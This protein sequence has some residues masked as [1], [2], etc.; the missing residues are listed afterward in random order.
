MAL[1]VD[2]RGIER[3]A[4]LEILQ[5]IERNSEALCGLV[6]DFVDFME[7]EIKAVRSLSAAEELP[8]RELAWL[9]IGEVK[10]Q[11]AERRIL[12][13]DKLPS[14][15][16]RLKVHK[17]TLA[18]ALAH[19]LENAVKF[20]PSG[21]I[22]NLE[23]EKS[24]DAVRLHVTDEGPG[25]PAA[26][27]QAVFQVFH[28]VDKRNTGD[29]PGLGLGL[30]IARQVIQEHGGDIQ[31]ASPYRYPDHGCRVTVLLPVTT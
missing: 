13:C 11:A 15:L 5:D 10:D 1:K 28:Q 6:N 7:M 26:D 25:I 29:V 20:S 4:R 2:T 17:Q 23:G 21:G 24:G 14:D 18:K 12:I 9:A 16:P 19:I 27:Q 8:L 30:A 3:R 22:V 31:I